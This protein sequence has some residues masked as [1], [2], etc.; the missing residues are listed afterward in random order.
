MKIGP[1]VW[2]VQVIHTCTH[3][4]TQLDIG[5]TYLTLVGGCGGCW[6]VIDITGKAMYTVYG[7]IVNCK[8]LPMCTLFLVFTNVDPIYIFTNVD[9]S[10]IFYQCGPQFG[11]HQ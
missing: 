4:N 8:F 10:F 5:I 7:K 1:A 9:P 11:P 2:P 6:A 3:T